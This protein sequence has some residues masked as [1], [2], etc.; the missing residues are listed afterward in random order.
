MSKK[1]ALFHLPHYEAIEDCL[2][3]PI[4]IMSIAAYLKRELS[5]VEVHVADIR[6]DDNIHDRLAVYGPADVYGVTAYTANL[7]FCAEILGRCKRDLNPNATTVLGGAGVTG[8][9]DSMLEDHKRNVD[10]FIRGPGEYPMY[11][12]AKLEPGLAV[13][14][15]IVNEWDLFDRPKF[16]DL[17]SPYNADIDLS[18]YHRHTKGKPTASVFTSRGCPFSCAF[19]GLPAEHHGTVEYRDPLHVIAEIGHLWAQKAIEAINFQDD[20]FLLDKGRAF[21]ILRNCRPMDLEYKVHGRAGHD[22]EDDYKRLRDLG[23]TMISWGIESG[24]PEILRRMN[25]KATVEDNLNVIRWA[26]K[27]GIVSRAFLVV[28]FPGETRKTIEETKRFIEQADPDQYFISTFQPYPGTPVSNRA[29]DY[30]ITSIYRNF[31]RYVQVMGRNQTPGSNID[32]TMTSRE[33]LTEIDVEF[34]QWMGNRPF[35]GPKQDYET[36]LYQEQD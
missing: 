30:D 22:T 3:P 17:P 13:P 21:D 15:L 28:G 34:R 25:K 8:A 33:E 20:V 24:S 2:D 32:T 26:K 29:T 11:L 19:C 5:D 14:N 4:G 12:I 6:K 27:L 31:D 23:V 36:E 16:G 10:I 1:I 18:V 9:T 35:R 7:R